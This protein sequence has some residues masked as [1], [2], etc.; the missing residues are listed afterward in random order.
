MKVRLKA[1]VR[2]NATVIYSYMENGTIKVLFNDHVTGKI[3]E[4]EYKTFKSAQASVTKF[5]NSVNRNA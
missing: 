5:F 3:F 4:R 2:E 1:M